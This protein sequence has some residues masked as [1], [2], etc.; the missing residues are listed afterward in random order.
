MFG[1][2][3]SK[4]FSAK[5]TFKYDSYSSVVTFIFYCGKSSLPVA[6]YSSQTSVHLIDQFEAIKMLEMSE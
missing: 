4:F 1:V 2:S 5:Q 6:S 3:K